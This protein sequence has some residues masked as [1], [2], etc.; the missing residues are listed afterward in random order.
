M[1]AMLREG[2]SKQGDVALCI[3]FGAGLSYA[4]Q[5]VRLPAAPPVD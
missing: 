4:G 3:G 5:V 1:E 2:Q